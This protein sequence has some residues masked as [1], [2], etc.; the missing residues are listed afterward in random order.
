MAASENTN[1]SLL[2]E[3]LQV[4]F[5]ENHRLKTSLRHKVYKVMQND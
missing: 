1:K 3:P 5:I 2:S 4:A